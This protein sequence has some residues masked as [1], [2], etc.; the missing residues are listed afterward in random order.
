M[1]HI[2]SGSLG[3]DFEPS[4]LSRLR[5]Y[6]QNENNN[7]P[8]HV[9]TYT[10]YVRVPPDRFHKICTIFCFIWGIHYSLFFLRVLGYEK[11]VTSPAPKKVSVLD[12]GSGVVYLNLDISIYICIYIYT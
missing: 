9:L 6:V 3:Q 4:T 1:G 11:I 5:W 12:A 7:G 8:I 10:S 2:H